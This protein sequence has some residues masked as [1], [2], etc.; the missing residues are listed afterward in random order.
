VSSGQA[1]QA[2]RGRAMPWRRGGSDVARCGA[3]RVGSG[4][5]NR[6]SALIWVRSMDSVGLAKL[7]GLIFW[8]KTEDHAAQQRLVYSILLNYWHR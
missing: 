1:L 4:G 6:L 5:S 7:D 8:V 3:R 2:E